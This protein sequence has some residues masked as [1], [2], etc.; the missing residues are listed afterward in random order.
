M[1]YFLAMAMML[2]SCNKESLVETNTSTPTGFTPNVSTDGLFSVNDGVQVY[3]SQGNLQYQAST[4]MWRF[5]ENQWDYVGCQSPAEGSRG[6]T[7]SESDNSQISPNYDGWIDLFGWGTSG[8]HNSAD[9]SNQNYQPWSSSKNEL[10]ENQYNHYGYGP[11]ANMPSTN[12]TNSSAYYDW[13]VYNAICNGGNEAGQWRTLTMNEWDYVFNARET[14]S[15]TRFAKATVNGVCGVILLPDNW[16]N[17]YYSL[18]NANEAEVDYSCNIIGVAQW[19]VLESYGVVFLPA[20]GR[21]SGKSVESAG[22]VGVYWSASC[23]DDRFH[24]NNG[25]LGVGVSFE[26]DKLEVK[27]VIQRYGGRSVRLVRDAQ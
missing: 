1:L 27:V 25:A 2:M 8:Y 24:N 5:A 20:G 16:E 23:F 13:G 6:G 19:A 10:E 4:G 21:R 3:F 17:S 26:Q 7:V 15:D 11:S 9:P 18:A 14:A 22:V 12:L